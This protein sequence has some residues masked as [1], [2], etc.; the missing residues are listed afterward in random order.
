MGQRFKRPRAPLAPFILSSLAV[1]G[2]VAAVG[3][4]LH[5]GSQKSSGPAELAALP[6]VD[7]DPGE[8]VVD[9]RDGITKAQYDQAE[10]QWGIDVEFNSIEGEKDGITVGR[11]DPARRDALLAQ[12]RQDPS[13]ERAEPLFRYRA[14]FVPNDPQFKA[15]WNFEQ[16]G[17]RQAWDVTQGA[18]VTIAVIDTG[19]AYEDYGEFRKVP[20]LEGVRFA[21]G[22]DF[23]NR[24]EHPNDDH[25]HGT[26]VAGTLAQATDN[27]QGVAGIAF[28]AT[29]MPLKVLDQNG[30]G[31]SADIADAIRWAA[32][33]G[34][35]VLNLSL[36]GGARSEVL[37]AAVAYARGR[38][39]VVVCA[40]GNGARGQVEYPAAY[41]GAI[42][43]SAVGPTGE[44]ASYSSYGQELDLA[45]PGGDKR[46]R[47]REEDGVLQNTIDPRDPGRSIYAYFN[48]TSM[49]AP[50]VAGA[51]ALLFAAG[52]RSPDEVERA[53]F[54]GADHARSGDW[55]DR[56]GHGLLS[57][58]GAL[59]AL[60][61]APGGPWWKKLL[62]LAFA[63]A[64]WL[65][66]RITLPAPVRRALR[67]GLGT[68][69]A[70][71]VAVLGFFFLPWLGLGQARG[72]SALAHPIPEW[73][74][75][76]FGGV[77]ANPLFFSALLPALL[78]M[79]GF[80]SPPLHGVLAGL[81]VGFAAV[82][83]SRALSGSAAVAFLPP[84]LGSILW[85]AL[86]AAFLLFL[87]RAAMKSAGERA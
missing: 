47:G 38:G 26:H 4:A 66:T 8:I 51:A 19:I 69:S 75:A 83:L 43:V 53:L 10:K 68:L 61:R 34:A 2:A 70:L 12:I 54:E 65:L 57:A 23:V 27:G 52:A 48:G 72:I 24:D 3:A 49:A 32:D 6:E 28:K 18:G 15:Q 30:S 60:G 41:P 25:G 86:N 76:V 79:V 82:L 77:A 84:G 7:W 45:A 40:A 74:N 87:A 56:F 29:L 33:H 31:T 35:K 59:Q 13:V 64:L 21:Q 62:T 5:R 50:H 71:A 39:A 36:G 58:S 37:Q 44:L 14:S 78:A 73:G 20:D 9:F 85:L 67:P 81:A 42:A 22:Y 1:V 11:V 63:F 17:M 80:R 16:I 55:S 46:L